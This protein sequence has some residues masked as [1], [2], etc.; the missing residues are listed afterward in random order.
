MKFPLNRLYSYNWIDWRLRWYIKRPCSEQ[1]TWKVAYLWLDV[2][3]AKVRAGFDTTAAVAVIG[4]VAG[5]AK[6]PVSEGV[7]VRLVVVPTV[8]SVA[9]LMYKDIVALIF[10]G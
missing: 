10:Y 8:Q 2:F 5:A 3:N 1:V 4:I 7:T 6:V 9:S